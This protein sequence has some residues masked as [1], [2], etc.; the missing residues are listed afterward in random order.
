MTIDLTFFSEIMVAIV[1]YYFVL[2]LIGSRGVE[3]PLMSQAQRPIVVI[4]VPARNEE[5]VIEETTQAAL[6]SPYKGA[7]RVLVMDDA[8]SDRTS[9]IVGRLAETDDR[10]RLVRRSPVVGGKGKSDV[11]NHAYALLTHWQKNSDPWLIGYSDRRIILCILDADGR[12]SPSAL[13][14]ATSFFCSRRVGAVQVAVKIRNAK[15]SVVAR[16]QDMEFVGF[17]FMVQTARDRLGSVGLGGNGQFTRMSALADLGD[18]P[19]QPGAL[20][21]DLDLGLRMMMAG[22]R[23]RFCSSSWVD[24][25][26]LTNLRPLLRQ[27]TRWAQGHYQ[28]WRHVPS[29]FRSGRMRVV[30]RIDTLAYLVLIVMVMLVTGALGIR[31]L[32]ALGLLT[33]TNDFI[34]WLGS[35]IAYRT[36]LLILSWLPILLTLFTYQK[37]A[38]VRLH[39]WETP[40]YMVI[41]AV[42][43]YLWALATVCAWTRS[44]LRR[45]NWVKTPRVASAELEPAFASEPLQNLQDGGLAARRGPCRVPAMGCDAKPDT[46][47]GSIV[48]LAAD[49]STPQPSS[50]DSLRYVDIPSHTRPSP[51][52]VVATGG[53]VDSAGT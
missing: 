52:N 11:L 16:M 27:R 19:W 23:L 38:V 34:P 47:P 17:S 41:F 4:I 30:S 3:L 43:V 49:P 40:C 10:L 15:E 53:R 32:G 36:T 35:G 9:E 7:L 5:M 25:Q 22:W 26:G 46:W 42:Y 12:L 37:H 13:D 28:C 48:G 1:S 24:Q 29:I 45:G 6:L 51:R 18:R 39:W 21:E 8:S 14:D 20:T 33:P 31:I 2:F 44:I 50:G